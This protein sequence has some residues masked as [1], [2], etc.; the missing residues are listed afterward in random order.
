MG[1]WRQQQSRK[2]GCVRRNETWPRFIGEAPVA[3]I[4]WQCM[5]DGWMGDVKNAGSHLSEHSQGPRQQS[6]Q[7]IHSI[8]GLKGLPAKVIVPQQ[9]HYASPLPHTPLMASAIWLHLHSEAAK[10][11]EWQPPRKPSL[12]LP[13]GWCPI[14]ATQPPRHKP[15]RFSLWPKKHTSMASHKRLAAHMSDSI[16]G[17]EEGYCCQSSR[18][19]LG[20]SSQIQAP[21]NIVCHKT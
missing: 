4:Q 1:K 7:V 16:L 21:L 11:H 18:H 20:C 10:R 9:Y 17:Q 12:R 19:L 6:A 3:A 8:I 5:I 14:T 15:P 13:K 2:G